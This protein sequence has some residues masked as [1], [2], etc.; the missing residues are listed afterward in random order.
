MNNIFDNKNSNNDV[1]S[2][3]NVS[4]MNFDG[5][6]VSFSSFDFQKI[7]P[8]EKKDT[9]VKNAFSAMRFKKKLLLKKKYKDD[10]VKERHIS[11]ESIKSFSK[12]LLKNLKN[13][14]SSFPFIENI[15]KVNFELLSLEY[16]VDEVKK[17][18]GN[19]FWAYKKIYSLEKEYLRKLSRSKDLNFIFKVKDSFIA[20]SISIL[21]QIDKSFVFLEDFRRFLKKLPVLKEDYFIVSIA[22]FPNVG[23]S[24][25]LKKLTLANPE[26]NSYPFTT[27]K[28]NLGLK[29]FDGLKVQFI[30]TPG[31]LNREKSNIIEKKAEI[32]IK[33]SHSVIYVFDPSLSYSFEQQLSLFKKILEEKN[34]VIVYFSKTDLFDYKK[35]F[36]LDK[37]KKVVEESK[38][39]YK[40][41]NFNVIFCDN[42]DCIFSSLKD[43]LLKKE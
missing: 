7:K 34:K 43:F 2:K 38:N 24:T 15:D 36:D 30:D 17:H 26:I 27:K 42:V 31:T 23:K 6:K 4:D 16:D 21:N 40:D 20:R 3:G 12:S 19:F 22:G 10:V 32:I 41:K 35:V 25:L 28:L 33:Y 11:R 9:I 14:F 29:K 1:N 18:L 37:I 39:K 5:E 13:V 8:V